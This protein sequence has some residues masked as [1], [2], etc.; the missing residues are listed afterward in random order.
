[1]VVAAGKR[2]KTRAE[3]RAENQARW[4]DNPANVYSSYVSAKTVLKTK[5]SDLVLIDGLSIDALRDMM[6]N[7]DEDLPRRV[8]AA[9]VVL[10]YELPP[11][12][13]VNATVEPASS[14]AYIFLKYLAHM[15]EAPSALKF[16]VLK[17]LSAVE[18]AKPRKVDPQ[19]VEDQRRREIR[20]INAARRAE[21]QSRGLWPSPVR[22]WFV[23]PDD[24][25]DFP[26]AA[27]I[28]AQTHARTPEQY[29]AVRI[30]NRPD[31]WDDLP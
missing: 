13:L 27:D 26:D 29:L 12:A 14:E 28:S 19:A 9:E 8:E 18:S 16:R 1:M 17:A 5:A 25:I 4:P 2:R 3:K 7:D 31:P 30:T 11:A 10:G 22:G 23:G 15:Q 20:L 6:R 21:L 24:M